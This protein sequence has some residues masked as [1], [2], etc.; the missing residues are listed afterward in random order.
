MLGVVAAG[1]PP[2]VPAT[3]VELV[4]LEGL[5]V[6]STVCAVAGIVV[7]YIVGVRVGSTSLMDIKSVSTC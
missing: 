1:C 6:G 2:G 5:V 4:I 7:G 3:G